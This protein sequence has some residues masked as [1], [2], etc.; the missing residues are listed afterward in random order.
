MVKLEIIIPREVS[1]KHKYHMVSLACGNL[2]YNTKEPASGTETV[3]DTGK[4]L[5]AAYGEGPGRACYR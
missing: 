1:Q 4:G 3:A 2:N 5:V